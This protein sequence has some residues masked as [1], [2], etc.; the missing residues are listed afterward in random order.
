ME[1]RG[2]DPYGSPFG[3]PLPSCSVTLASAYGFRIGGHVQHYR[4][5]TAT[6]ALQRSVH[7]HEEPMHAGEARVR[8]NTIALVVNF[9]DPKEYLLPDVK[10]ETIEFEQRVWIPREG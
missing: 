7:R 4:T 10:H 9:G 8:C 1:M 2:P 5:L 3:N 6:L